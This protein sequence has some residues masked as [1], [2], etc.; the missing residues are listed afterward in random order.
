[1][2]PP[3][4]CPYCGCLVGL[5]WSRGHAPKC[6]RPTERREEDNP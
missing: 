5:P 3:T 6:A 4:R 2:T 1:M